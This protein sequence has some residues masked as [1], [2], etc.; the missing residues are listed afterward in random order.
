MASQ[1][2]EGLSSG[3]KGSRPSGRT[4]VQSGELPGT[5][6]GQNTGV[7][8]TGGRRGPAGNSGQY[9]AEGIRDQQGG[10]T[11]EHTG[12]NVPGR[13]LDETEKPIHVVPSQNINAETTRGKPRTNTEGAGDRG[14]VQEGTGRANAEGVSGTD[15]SVLDLLSAFDEEVTA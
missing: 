7:N 10:E 8:Q 5:I 9:A 4:E 15:N 6:R 12:E 2:A 1:G 3:E 11:G 13:G 14:G